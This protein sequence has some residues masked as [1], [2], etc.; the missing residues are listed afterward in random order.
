MIAAAFVV[1][2]VVPLA[3]GQPVSDWF[4]RGLVLLVI[5]CPCALVI[6]TPVS[7]VSALAAAARRGVLVKGG[8]HLERA[9]AIRCVALDKTGTLTHG[10]PE[11]AHVVGLGAA[12]ARDVIG[13]AAAIESR[14]E[15]P[16]GR[17]IMRHAGREGV[18]VAAGEG[19]RAIPGRGVEAQ[20]NGR[21]GL[22][23]NHR[24]FEERR[25]CTPDCTTTWTHWRDEGTR[26]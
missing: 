18:D 10:R 25:L 12:S 23:G 3:A 2:F 13:T 6:A 24:L 5:A 15:H 16:I 22:L 14:S 4:Y 11:V 26:P 19:H 7:I 8:L 1:M 9:S 20:V 21:S 17:A